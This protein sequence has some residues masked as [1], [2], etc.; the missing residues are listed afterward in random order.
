MSEGFTP[1][2]EQVPTYQDPY[3]ANPGNGG[4][5]GPQCARLTA[6][7]RVFNLVGG[8]FAGIGII[9]LIVGIAVGLT[10]LDVGAVLAF[11]GLIFAVLGLTLVITAVRQ[12]RRARELLEKGLP[13]TGT[14][15]G[16][17]ENLSVAI[18]GRHPYQIRCQVYPPGSEN[19]QEY[20]SADWSADPTPTLT[21]TGTTTLPVYVDQA[22]PAVGYVDDSQLR[23]R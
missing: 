2:G 9:L 4:P 8:I 14:I 21:A 10:S 1:P 15:A 16:V 3:A 13:M 23:P 18:N 22:N 11:I 19:P 7:Q 17:Q 20:L 12:F 6:S 5:S